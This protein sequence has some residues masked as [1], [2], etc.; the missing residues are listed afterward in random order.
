MEINDYIIG[1]VKAINKIF[2][3][4]R[5][6]MS[7]EQII[8]RELDEQDL[9]N[10]QR[11]QFD[12]LLYVENGGET[13]LPTWLEKK[14]LKRCAKYGF[15]FGEVVGTIAASPIVAA[16]YAK[17]ASRQSVA[18]KVQLDNFNKHGLK[19]EKLSKT[20]GSAMRL[21]DTGE[22]VFGSLGSRG[23][24]TKSFDSRRGNDLILQ[25]FTNEPGGAQDNQGRDAITYL[26]AAN[27]YVANNDS[28]FRF[29]AV[30]DGPYYRRNWARF[31]QYA[32]GKILVE[33]SDSYI[34]KCKNE[35]I[36]KAV[37]RK[38][39]NKVKELTA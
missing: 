16:E 24:G 31:N 9:D 35:V 20:G 6:I 29:V 38:S 1:M 15:R 22:L 34:N 5:I 8:K 30:L 3:R 4:R 13:P 19:V 37:T 17:K 36:K 26:K 10:A 11:T 33:N 2:K 12:A 39:V 27:K 32:N 28:K 18:E 7:T 25:K 14:I 23:V 21:L